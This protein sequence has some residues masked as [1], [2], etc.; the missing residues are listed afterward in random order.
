MDPFI[1]IHNL[2]SGVLD[3]DMLEEAVDGKIRCYGKEINYRMMIP[4]QPTEEQL[5]HFAKQV[6]PQL[7][8]TWTA[9]L[10]STSK[11]DRCWLI[12]QCLPNTSFYGI[13]KDEFQDLFSDVIPDLIQRIGAIANAFEVPFTNVVP[14][15]DPCNETEPFGMPVG[16]I[17]LLLYDHPSSSFLDCRK[18]FPSFVGPYP[19]GWEI[20]RKQ[21]DV[22][23]K[24]VQKW[25]T[26]CLA[27]LET[28]HEMANAIESLKLRGISSMYLSFGWYISLRM[29]LFQH[30]LI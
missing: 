24:L 23:E 4:V 10:K 11:E 29:L 18:H 3:T 26:W 14:L 8:D 17:P 6:E 27:G 22:C 20:V 30:T 15:I 5:D 2:L 13:S 12:R 16:V 1:N 9:V 7:Y 19:D 25:H 21:L 28:T